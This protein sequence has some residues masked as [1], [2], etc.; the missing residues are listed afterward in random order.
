MRAYLRQLRATLPTRQGE[1]EVCERI[2]A[3]RKE[4]RAAV[5]GSR[6]ATRDVLD[7]G[8][9]L[10]EHGLRASDLSGHEAGDDG[11][12]D[13]ELAS[14]RLLQAID[15]IE[16]LQGE[17]HRLCG[18]H[19]RATGD[20]KREL[21]HSLTRARAQSRRRLERMKLSDKAISEIAR[22]HKQRYSEFAQGDL[23][24]LERNSAE[25]LAATC[26]RIRTGERKARLA[27]SELIEANL[28]L[29]VSIAKKYQHRGL[30]LLDLIQEGNI[31]LMRA[32][33]KFDYRRG[34]KFS[35]YGTWWIRQAITR[36]LADQGRTIRIPVHMT[37]NAKQIL[38]TSRQL[39]QKLGRDPTPEEIA[40]QMEWPLER[41]QSVVD[42]VK[43]P[44]SLQTP[45]G[46]DGDTHLSDFVEDRETKSA[47]H[48]AIERD[49]HEH[50]LEALESLSLREQRIIKLRF[51]IGEK[52][53]HTLEEIGREFNVTRERIRQIEAQAIRKLRNPLRSKPLKDFLPD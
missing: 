34:Y 1:A 4:V 21:A 3:G 15:R 23:K 31:G 46:D 52:S 6:T 13:D 50:T 25:Q 9:R 30:P 27:K 20:Q 22:K 35:T 47:L 36:M 39:V 49:L 17:I 5:L 44:L 53:E 14:R 28:R 10:R 24:P 42:L 16:R 11:E 38:R 40:G 41:V 32:V 48:A 26:E 29:V 33:D 2:E 45:I 43:E 18:Q 12:P 7:L 8:K 51:G 19:A 37:E